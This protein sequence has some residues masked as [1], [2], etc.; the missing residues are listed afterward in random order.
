MAASPDKGVTAARGRK[1]ELALAHRNCSLAV[2]DKFTGADWSTEV[3]AGGDAR[4]TMFG[5]AELLSK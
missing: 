1:V 5:A 4:D 3:K 2:R